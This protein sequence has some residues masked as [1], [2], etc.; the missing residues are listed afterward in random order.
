MVMW[1]PQFDDLGLKYQFILISD[2]YFHGDLILYSYDGYGTDAVVYLKTLT[3]QAKEL[4]PLFNKAITKQYKT[5][6]TESDWT[7]SENY[8]SPRELS[9]GNIFC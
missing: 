8:F 6:T 9:G 4:L 5:A 3:Q 2:R 7:D 1:C